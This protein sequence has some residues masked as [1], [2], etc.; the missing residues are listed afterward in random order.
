MISAQQRQQ[1][2]DWLPALF[3]GG[4][5][6]IVF[7]AIGHTPLIRASGM[8]LA[9]IGMALALRPM[10]TALS[11]IGGLALAFSPSFWIQTGGAESLNLLEVVAALVAA[12][13]AAGA[14]LLL[15]KRPLIG[16]AAGLLLF[17][18]IFLTG[19]RH[20]AQFTPDDTC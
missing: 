18:G 2:R 17:A 9:V 1:A 14:V 16:A 11:V 20:T 13:V 12:A 4:I 8:A 3:V 7:I 6:W 5:A 19:S 15:S 10:G